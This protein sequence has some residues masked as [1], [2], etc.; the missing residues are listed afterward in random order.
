M[1]KVDLNFSD[2]EPEAEEIVADR[3]FAHIL[4]RASVF[5][6]F[7]ANGEKSYLAVGRS[8]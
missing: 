8:D 3:F 6:R 5:S 2:L 7:L 4:T 1:R